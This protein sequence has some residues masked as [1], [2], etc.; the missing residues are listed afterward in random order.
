MQRG[1]ERGARGGIAAEQQADAPLRGFEIGRRPESCELVP[2]RPKLEVGVLVV[3]HEYGH[4]AVARLCGVKVLRFS[5]G[6]GR[7]LWLRRFG[8]PSQSESLWL[9][10]GL[11]LVLVGLFHKA[12][13]R[14]LKPMPERSVTNLF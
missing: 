10:P 1:G 14:W 13:A 12:E 7:P 11:C 3:V 8:R 5:V 4:Y 9:L 2:R 6:F